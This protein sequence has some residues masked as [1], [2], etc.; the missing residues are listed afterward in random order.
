MLLVALK[1]GET[2]CHCEGRA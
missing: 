1:G 2:H